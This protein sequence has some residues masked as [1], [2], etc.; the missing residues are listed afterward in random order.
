MDYR[1]V[2]YDTLHPD[3]IAIRT[4]VFVEEQ[5]FK[6]EFDDM[7]AS[8]THL[9][10]YD[11]DKPVATGRLLFQDGGWWIGRVAVMRPYRGAHLGSRILSELEALARQRGADS[12]SLGAQ[13]RV[14]AFYESAGYTAVPEYHDEEGIPHVK[15]CKA[16]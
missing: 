3:C 1:A 10:L 16:L 8:S 7:D 11:G 9:V 4:A 15:M 2:F 14:Q 5:G 12:V 13:C 6:Y